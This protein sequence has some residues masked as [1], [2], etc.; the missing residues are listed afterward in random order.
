LRAKNA[1]RDA[2]DLLASHLHAIV[3]A[4][5]ARVLGAAEDKEAVDVLI[6]AATT[7]TD[8]RVRVAAIRALGALK[9]AKAADPLL[10]R[11]ENLLAAYTQ[12]FKPGF[13]P[14]EH[15]EFL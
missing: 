14:A 2:R 7:D 9:D 5:A 8:S 10:A 13:L 4:N 12:A 11:G 6:K 1:N 15:S 3:R